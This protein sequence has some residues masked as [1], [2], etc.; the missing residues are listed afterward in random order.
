MFNHHKCLT[1]IG[2]TLRDGLVPKTSPKFD[3]YKFKR[4]FSIDRIKK[5]E[6]VF[7]VIFDVSW[8]DFKDNVEMSYQR[9]HTDNTDYYDIQ[10]SKFNLIRTILYFYDSIKYKITSR[11]GAF[12]NYWQYGFWDYD[13]TYSL[14]WVTT[15]YLYERVKRYKD[16]ASKW[17]KLYP[18]NEE[19]YEGLHKY[20]NI[21]VVTLKDINEIKDNYYKSEHMFFK[22]E[23][24]I[25]TI[26]YKELYQ[27]ECIDL[28]LEYLEKVIKTEQ[29]IH[30]F[31]EL[32]VSDKIF[33]ELLDNVGLDHNPVKDNNGKVM[34]YTNPFESINNEQD[35]RDPDHMFWSC[36]EE[37]YTHILQSYAFQIYGKIIRS[38]WW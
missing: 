36:L 20:K 29:G 26:E 23:D 13:E 15:V 19:D 6:D 4:Y 35:K 5:A 27:Y 21:P 7:D 34:Y 3:M 38:M 37:T 12:K 31:K 10:D 11:W 14:D 16:L 8:P 1:D 22:D 2:I 17:V 28:I 24:S 30:M 32:D 25:V 33:N 9:N 18:E